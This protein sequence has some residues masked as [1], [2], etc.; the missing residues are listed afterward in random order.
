MF[1][2]KTYQYIKEWS[3]DNYYKEI[4]NNHLHKIVIPVEKTEK[5]LE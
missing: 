1:P 2:W 5:K 3:E 4:K